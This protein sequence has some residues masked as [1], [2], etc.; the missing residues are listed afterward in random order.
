MN[1]GYPE[2][3]IRVDNENAAN[4]LRNVAAAKLEDQILNVRV[5]P[6]P[7]PYDLASSG[8]S[9]SSVQQIKDKTGILV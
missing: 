5:V 1:L 8:A 4:A 7:P 9:E 6:N 3:I 2:V